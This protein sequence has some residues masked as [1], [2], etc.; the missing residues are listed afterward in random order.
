MTYD[1]T[2]PA[3]AGWY[4]D[5]EGQRQ[6]RVWTG[7]EWSTT[8]RPYGE[9][10]SEPDSAR[11]TVILVGSMQRL[12]R[13][14]IVITFAGLGLVVGVLA[15]WPGT[16]H[17]SPTW[18][19]VLASDVGVALLMLGSLVF[20]FAA[21]ALQGRWSVAAWVPGVNILLVNGLVLE[22]LTERWP[23]QRVV[24]E[25]VLMALFIAQSHAYPWLGIVPAVIALNHLGA[26]S[27]LVERLSTS[28][29]TA[30]PSGS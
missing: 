16:A 8:T 28:R 12:V 30:A 24:S 4:P 9:R 10:T 14:G 22:R 7:T 5:P 11:E 19:A 21:R 20:A 25:S 3:P 27:A 17:P 26:T 1:P 6:W 23:V 13:Y 2:S 15:H 18:F 29:A